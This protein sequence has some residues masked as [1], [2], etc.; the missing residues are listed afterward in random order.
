MSAFAVFFMQSA[1]FLTYQR[2]MNKHKGNSNAHTLFQIEQIPSDNQTRNLLDP[3]TPHHFD[4]EFE[5]VHAELKESGIL[6]GFRDY[7]N[8]FLIAIDG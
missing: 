4:S 2:D 7:G 3:I 5:W 8:T 1:S 6:E